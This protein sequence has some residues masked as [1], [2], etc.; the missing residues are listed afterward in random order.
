[1]SKH[2]EVGELRPNE[3]VRRSNGPKYFGYSLTIIDE[4]IKSGEIP[5]PMQLGERARGWLGSQIIDW[6]Q[7]RLAELKSN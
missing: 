1:M 3:I 5:E 6:Q 4:K 7:K 2:A